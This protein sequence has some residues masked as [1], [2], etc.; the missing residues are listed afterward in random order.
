VVVV[1]MPIS[2]AMDN[3]E[4]DSDGGGGGGGGG[5]SGRRRR[6]SM[7]A[8]GGG[9]QWRQQR[10]TVTAVGATDRQYQDDDGN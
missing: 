3:S 10:L 2:S 5:G 1:L 6:C 8:E 7:A 4:F 9:V